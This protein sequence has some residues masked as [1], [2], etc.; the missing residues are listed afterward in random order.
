M[1]RLMAILN[2][3]P[4]SFSDGGLHFDPADAIRAGLQMVG[5]GADILDIGGEST[6]PGAPVVSADE[7]ASRVVPV[8]AGLREV[9]DIPISIDTTKASVA[10]AAIDAGAGIINDISGFERD[11]NMISLAAE[12]AADCVV[13]HM[14]GTPQTMQQHL[15]Y[16]DLVGDIRNYFASRIAALRAAGVA[17]SAIILDPGIGF[18][19]SAEQNLVLI[20]R[21]AE[22]AD[23]GFPILLGPSRKSFIG[24]TLGIDDPNE[25][26]WGTAASVA[27]GIAN[28]ATIIRVHDVP[29]MRQVC[30]LAKAII[31]A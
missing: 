20:Q 13:M 2:V 4:D 31:E 7:E 17:D 15:D 3:T 14:R 24:R 9:C 6:R 19:K 30:D 12:S 1:I 21:L 25:R 11:P 29:E 10:R 8:I 5:Q 22:F 16:D 26:V 18:A 27:I 28:G 23:L